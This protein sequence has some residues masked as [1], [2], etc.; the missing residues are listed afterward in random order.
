MTQGNT[1]Y[2]NEESYGAQHSIDRD[3][4]TAAVAITDS[5][6]SWLKL[7]FDQPYTIQKIIIYYVF[8][9]DWYNSNDW[10]VKSEANFRSCV[11]NDSNVDVSV[12]Q[13]EVKKGSCGILQL[14]YGLEKADQIYTLICNTNGTIV[15]LTTLNAVNIAIY[16]LVILSESEYLKIVPY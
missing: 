13:E 7:H 3:F 8:Y 1:L 4:S 11:D 5:E 9:T 14:T 15:K 16:E 2:N 12:Y 10:C 6:A